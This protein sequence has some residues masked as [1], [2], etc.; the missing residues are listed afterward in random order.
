MATLITVLLLRL[1]KTKRSVKVAIRQSQAQL[2]DITKNTEYI[3]KMLE[4]KLE[5]QASKHRASNM[6]RIVFV[7]NQAYWI[8]DSVFYTAD[9]DDEGYIDAETTRAVDTM[10]MDKVQLEKMSFIVEKLTEGK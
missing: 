9:I 7:E 8:R 5:S 3:I 1:R 6:V 4:E 2:F 10:T